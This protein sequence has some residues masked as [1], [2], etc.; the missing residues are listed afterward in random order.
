[1]KEGD[2]ETDELDVT[3]SETD[4][5]GEN[6]FD[7]VSLVDTEGEED[8]EIDSVELGDADLD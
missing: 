8:S 5:V 1:M 7:G 4:S 6:D 2:S 3:V